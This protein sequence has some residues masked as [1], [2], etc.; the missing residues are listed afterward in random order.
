MYSCAGHG[1]G[2]GYI[3]VQMNDKT[4]GKIYNII[5]KLSGIKNISFRFSQAE[6]GKVPSFTVY[7]ENEKNKNKVMDII[8]DAMTQE[9]NKDNL[10]DDFKN[11][12]KIRDI[13]MKEKMG[14]DLLYSVGKYNNL[15]LLENLKFVNGK[16][17]EKE[18]FKKMGLKSRKDIVGR[19]QYFKNRISKNKAPKV[20]NNILQNLNQIYNI[21]SE[22]LYKTNKD[23]KNNQR[24]AFV[25]TMSDR[26]EDINGI[27]Y[28][29][30]NRN[31]QAINKSI[32]N[33]EK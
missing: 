30:N 18:D 28:N 2:E 15:L 23:F 7:F 33:L 27:V 17:L 22:S 19:L 3:T 5:S 16:Y 4:M 25:K 21:E 13:F 26:V 11:L 6:F 32:E 31:E 9:K 20:L 8:S 29:V 1:K 14:F 24:E 10:S 12:I